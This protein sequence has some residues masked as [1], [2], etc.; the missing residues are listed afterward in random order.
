MRAFFDRDITTI[1][2]WFTIQDRSG[3][4]I[5]NRVRARSGQKGHTNTSW[6]RSKSPIPFGEFN[7]YTTLNNKGL[8]AGKTGIGEAYPIDNRGDKYTIKQPGG[9]LIRE[10][11][12]LH[13]ENMWDG[14]AGC[15][16]IVRE[17][18]W[19]HVKETMETLRKL[20]VTKFPVEVL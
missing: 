14:S 16:V 5:V 11:I 12:M 20:G 18:D 7:L 2:G 6:V 8:K 4:K 10:E 17:S 19:L 1:E 3:K 15:I 13:Q 9:K